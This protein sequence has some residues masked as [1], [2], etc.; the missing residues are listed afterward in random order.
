[1]WLNCDKRGC[2]PQTARSFN[3]H[4]IVSDARADTGQ[5]R[6]SALVITPTLFHNIPGINLNIFVAHCHF[7]CSCIIYQRWLCRNITATPWMSPCLFTLHAGLIKKDLCYLSSP[8]SS[9]PLAVPFDYLLMSP[10][11]HVIN[12]KDG[13][14]LWEKLSL[15]FNQRSSKWPSL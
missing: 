2:R 13:V 4:L 7:K 5:R 10:S 6:A 3:R 9:C 11:L 14:L 12:C 15:V 1:M 8:Q